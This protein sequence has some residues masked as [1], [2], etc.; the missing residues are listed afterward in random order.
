MSRNLFASKTVTFG[1]RQTVLFALVERFISHSVGDRVNVGSIYGM[2]VPFSLLTSLVSAAAQLDLNKSAKPAVF[3]MGN[4]VLPSKLSYYHSPPDRL[5]SITWFYDPL[6]I[7]PAA[8]HAQTKYIFSREF[9]LPFH[10]ILG[11]L[12]PST[13]LFLSPTKLHVHTLLLGANLPI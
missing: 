4:E 8:F 3:C 1:N 7:R 6:S 2:C 5:D 12:V 9:F 13:L 11:I 10:L